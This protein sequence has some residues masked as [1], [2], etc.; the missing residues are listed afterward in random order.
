VAPAADGLHSL[1]VQIAIGRARRCRLED[2]AGRGYGENPEDAGEV[3]ARPALPRRPGAHFKLAEEVGAPSL[4]CTALGMP[5]PS[6][7]PSGVSSGRAQ[8]VP[9]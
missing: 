9:S 3:S 1:R 6:V 2:D 8:H 5:S 4:A 7:F